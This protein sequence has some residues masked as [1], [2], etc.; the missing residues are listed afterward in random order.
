V[1]KD[2]KTERERER[3]DNSLGILGYLLLFNPG[4][5]LGLIK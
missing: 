2:G 5:N 1:I 3:A 4:V